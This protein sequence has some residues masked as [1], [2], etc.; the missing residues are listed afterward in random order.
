MGAETALAQVIR[1]VHE[2]QGSKAPIQRLADQVAGIFVPVVIALAL[3]TFLVWW[4]V[5]GAGVTDAL[6][7][8]V[9]VLVIACPCALGLATPTAVMVGTGRGARRGILFRSSEA[10][11]R[12]KQ[13]SVV[14]IDKTGTIT[15]GEPVVREVVAFD[16]D[17]ARLLRLAASAEL[18]S[19]HPLAEAVLV[20]GEASGPDALGA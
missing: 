20:E 18:R 12:A 7:R 2:A 17:Q 19:E 11:E 3:A 1:L 10:L 16:G 8:L 4:L 5:V 13:V 6:I 14:V 15:R 9:A